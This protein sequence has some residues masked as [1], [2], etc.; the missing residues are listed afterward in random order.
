MSDTYEDANLVRFT[1]FVNPNFAWILLKKHRF[2]SDNVLF[3]YTMGVDTGEHLCYVLNFNTS[4]VMI[5]QIVVALVVES[6]RYV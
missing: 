5:F 6:Y 1:K 2:L 3:S 4:G